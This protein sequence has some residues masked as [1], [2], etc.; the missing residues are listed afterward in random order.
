MDSLSN[1]VS[2]IIPHRD[3]HGVIDLLETVSRRASSCSEE[4]RREVG[5]MAKRLRYKHS[6]RASAITRTTDAA[7][8]RRDFGKDAL[9]ADLLRGFGTLTAPLEEANSSHHDSMPQSPGSSPPH[10]DLLRDFGRS[11]SDES[12]QR[13]DGSESGHDSLD[14]AG[15]EEPRHL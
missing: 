15:F 1:I 7:E 14:D 8:Q 6:S 10:G 5:E 2:N 3:H 11:P 4:E 12:D 9:E 13:S